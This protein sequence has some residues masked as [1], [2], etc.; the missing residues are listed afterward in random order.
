VKTGLPESACI[1][2][3]VM[4]CSAA[5]V[6]TTWTVAPALTKARQSSADL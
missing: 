5:W 1:V 2:T 3:E 6:M 4:N